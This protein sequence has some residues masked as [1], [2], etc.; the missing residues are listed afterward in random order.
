MPSRNGK[1]PARKGKTGKK[2]GKSGSTVMVVSPINGAVMQAGAHPQ[3]TGGKPGRSGRHLAITKRLAAKKLPRHV[4]TLDEIAHG[5]VF[6]SIT[7]RCPKC[8][9]TP[10]TGT[11][12][13]LSQVRAGERVRA[14]EEL[15]KLAEGTELV[16]TGENAHSFFECVSRAMKEI[17]EPHLAE[18]V[19]DRARELFLTAQRKAS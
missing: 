6:V 8:K 4:R 18:A 19:H 7:E 17:I 10:S 14:I 1:R 16:V 11:T 15:R 9:Y 13:E 5:E 3:N 12:V 2:T